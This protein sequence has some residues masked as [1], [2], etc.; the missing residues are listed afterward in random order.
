MASF[1]SMSIDEQVAIGAE[2]GLR[3]PD[4]Q[5]L[6]GRPFPEAV[7]DQSLMGPHASFIRVSLFMKCSLGSRGSAHLTLPCLLLCWMICFRDNGV[8][9][10]VVV[11]AKSRGGE[12]TVFVTM[13]FSLFWSYGP[14]HSVAPIGAMT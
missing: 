10:S 9:G 12:V 14:N 3:D 5:F 2:Y 11:W 6:M 8:L 13:G 7:K 4:P 1:Q